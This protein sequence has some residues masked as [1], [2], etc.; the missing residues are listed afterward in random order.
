MLEALIHS[1]ERD[2]FLNLTKHQDANLEAFNSFLW[3]KGKSSNFQGIEGVFNA[4]PQ[5]VTKQGGL[6]IAGFENEQ[7]KELALANARML[8]TQK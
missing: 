7:K 6:V 2:E 8:Y 3:R 4:I 5:E 1:F